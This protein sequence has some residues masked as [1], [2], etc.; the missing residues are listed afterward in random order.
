VGADRKIPQ[1]YRWGVTLNV[2]APLLFGCLVRSQPGIHR[3]KGAYRVE[4][5]KSVKNVGKLYTFAIKRKGS[6]L[7]SDMLNS[8]W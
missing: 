6:S 4:T 1:R 8:R 5:D 3:I 2:T 7:I